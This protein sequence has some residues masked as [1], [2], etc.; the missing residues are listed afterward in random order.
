VRAGDPA[1]LAPLAA[2]EAVDPNEYYFR[3]WVTLETQAPAH[4]WV[5]GRLFIGVAARAPHAA[6]IDTYEIL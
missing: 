6:I 1:V 3:T 2:G 5:C 4:T